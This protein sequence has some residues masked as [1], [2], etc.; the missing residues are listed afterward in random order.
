MAVKAKSVKTYKVCYRGKP[1]YE[2]IAYGVHANFCANMQEVNDAI[3]SC[4]KWFNNVIVKEPVADLKTGKQLRPAEVEV[5]DNVFVWYDEYL[6]G[7]LNNDGEEAACGALSED[8]AT[9]QL[10]GSTEA[11]SAKK[12]LSESA[13]TSPSPLAAAT[14]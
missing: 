11:K 13:Q 10:I 5:R 4:K 9:K 2:D 6:D 14:V 3:A 12:S 8:T 7:Q 1:G